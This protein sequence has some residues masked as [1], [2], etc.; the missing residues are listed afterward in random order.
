[1]GVGVWQAYGCMDVWVHGCV[2]NA[3]ECMGVS[4]LFIGCN[5]GCMY[6]CMYG[7]VGVVL[8]FGFG[9]CF[10]LSFGLV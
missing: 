8:F 1:M 7:C 3:Y 6:V 10:V 9:F 5:D 2:G 4:G